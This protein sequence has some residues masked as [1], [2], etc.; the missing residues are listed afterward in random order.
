MKEWY[1]VLG[2]IL[3]RKAVKIARKIQR[4][5]DQEFC[6]LVKGVGPEERRLAVKIRK[7]GKRF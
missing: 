3:W 4:M 5:S 2:I 6:R 7:A 1:M